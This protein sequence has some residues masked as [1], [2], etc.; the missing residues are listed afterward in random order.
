MEIPLE[1]LGK[2]VRDLGEFMTCL[3]Q[4]RKKG[5]EVCKTCTLY[6]NV[7]HMCKYQLLIESIEKSKTINI[8]IYEDGTIVINKYVFAHLSDYQRQI[9]L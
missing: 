7:N 2:I 1:I 8:E 6:D 5:F 4:K 3:A 9:K